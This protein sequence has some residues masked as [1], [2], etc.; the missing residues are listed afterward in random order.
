MSLRIRQ[1]VFAAR[2]LAS[3]VAQVQAQLALPVVYRDPEV[4]HF[5]LQNA[6]MSIGDQFIEIISPTRADTAAGRHLDRHGDSAYMLIL[7]TDD[8][9]RE[10]ARLA[11]LGVRIVWESSYPDIQAI[12]LH[13]KDI[14][15]AIVSLD[16]ATPPSS[17][18]WAG[19]NWRDEESAPGTIVSATIAARDPASLSRRWATVLGLTAPRQVD[20]CWCLAVVDGALMFVP[21]RGGTERIVEFGLRAPGCPLPIEICGTR[22]STA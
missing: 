16:E 11:Q 5:G 14:G 4:A 22:L 8:L 19:P 12:H 1:I 10:R 21:S 13:P 15:G 20:D 18:R 17:W 2:D 3:S 7:Q 9:A 6:M